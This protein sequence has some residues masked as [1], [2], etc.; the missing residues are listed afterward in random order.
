MGSKSFMDDLI[1]FI[2]QESR[3]DKQPPV[4]I[5]HGRFLSDFPLLIVNFMKNNYEY[6]RPAK[7][8]FADS[9]RMLQHKG[10]K[11]AGLHSISTTVSTRRHSAVYDVK[12]YSTTSYCLVQPNN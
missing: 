11:K 8:T 3:N 12:L 2:N 5:V 10:Y 6:S 4:I 1:E 7:Y 9:M